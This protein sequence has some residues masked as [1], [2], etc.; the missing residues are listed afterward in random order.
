MIGITNWVY[1][2]QWSQLLVSLEV[3]GIKYKLK[4]FLGVMSHA[5]MGTPIYKMHIL[6][7]FAALHWLSEIFFVKII[8]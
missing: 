3:S 1:E 5:L 8:R 2:E 7:I 4:I 6:A